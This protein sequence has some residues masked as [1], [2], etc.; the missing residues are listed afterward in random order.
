[1]NG[2]NY[3]Y[4]GCIKGDFSEMDY[5]IKSFESITNIKR[6]LNHDSKTLNDQGELTKEIKDR[7]KRYKSWGFNESNT[8]FYQ[9]FDNEHPTVFKKFIDIT[10]LDDPV[11]SFI[12]QK[13]GNTLPFHRDTFIDYKLR[14]NLDPKNDKVVRYMIFMEDWQPGHTFLVEDEPII[15]WKKG[16]MIYW[17]S[18]YHVGSN[19]GRVP[20]TT[21]NITGIVKKNGLHFRN[22]LNLYF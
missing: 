7:I 19:A 1:M 13:P 18:K 15:N 10:E 5:L 6:L 9:V 14:N 11:A 20:K 21:L 3:K 12:T 8:T 4:I 16:D 2:N 22:N 17:G